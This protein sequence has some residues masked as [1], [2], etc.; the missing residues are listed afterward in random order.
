[1]R[2]AR[3]EVGTMGGEI[4]G[5]GPVKAW[6]EP[7]RWALLRAEPLR[8]CGLIAAAFASVGLGFW[9]HPAFFVLTALTLVRHAAAEASLRE[10]FRDGMLH[11]AKVV[12]RGSIATLVRLDQDGRPQDAVVISR[13]PRRWTR[14][15]PPWGGERA[16][17]VIA[18]DPPKLRPLSPDV[19]VRD[20]LRA[21]RA[22][23]RIPDRQWSALSNALAQ[24]PNYG[25]G[26][27]PVELG[28]APWYGTVRE[29]EVDGS[30]P[31]NL[32]SQEPHAWCACLPL[33]ERPTMVDAERAQVVR[34]RNRAWRRVALWLA[35]LGMSLLGAL[36]AGSGALAA[37]LWGLSLLA[38]PFVFAWC[39]VSV[40]RARAYGR[41]LRTGK[42]WR[43]A[44][45]V[46]AF[47]SLGSDRDLAQL[48][49]RA[50][51][52]P[53]PGV[54]QDLSLL[55]ES[56]QLLHANGKWAPPDLRLHVSEVAAPPAQAPK[57][58][59]PSELAGEPVGGLE[60]GRRRFS[61]AELQELE[62]Y[63]ARLRRPGLVLAL[64]T[65]LGVLGVCL[66]LEHGVQLP[67]RFA[68]APFAAALW[69]FAL[70]AFIRRLRFAARLRSDV[71]LGWVVTADHGEVG[72]GSDDPQLPARGV[73]SLLHARLDWTVNRRPA[74]WRRS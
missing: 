60:V 8:A 19:A 45:A 33:I 61:P 47:D 22:V 70:Q 6:I 5:G 27:H 65:P 71:E 59:L 54:E 16:A 69:L 50:V 10:L 21:Q 30:L 13:M 39:L 7:D 58:A 9:L 29:L 41:D 23:E 48:A 64:L 57:L 35:G 42:L 62:Q 3:A 68:S 17:M 11:P 56:R 18:G 25:E 31:A 4:A 43:F 37:T 40:R 63:A 15:L 28:G 73:E 44:G 1:M 53:E 55:A 24:L 26:V 38:G 72:D 36:L 46:S 32:G 66:L 49:R 20:V 12:A 34:W 51:I 52:T 74:A 14:K 2:L 67:L